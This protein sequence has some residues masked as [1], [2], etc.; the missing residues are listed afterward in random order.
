M[1]NQA[2]ECFSQKAFQNESTC[3]VELRQSASAMRPAVRAQSLKMPRKFSLKDV[4]D[5]NQ[6]LCDPD[7]A[8]TVTVSIRECHLVG[9]GIMSTQSEPIS[10]GK[11]LRFNELS[12]TLFPALAKIRLQLTTASLKN[13]G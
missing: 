11:L 5:L 6:N 12:F 10:N 9:A 1:L 4:T 3:Q 2:S 8:K 13:A 7:S